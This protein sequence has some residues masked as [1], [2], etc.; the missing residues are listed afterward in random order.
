MRPQSSCIKEHE[1][2]EARREEGDVKQKELVVCGAGCETDV[3]VEQ[4]AKD[5]QKDEA[6]ANRPPG[7]EQRRDQQRGHGESE[8]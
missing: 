4:V 1:G 3:D 7:V 5:A 2:E 6:P 8:D